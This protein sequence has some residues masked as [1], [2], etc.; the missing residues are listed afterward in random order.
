M[1]LSDE[2]LEK[3]G[4][5]VENAVDRRFQEFRAEMVVWRQETNASLIGIVQEMMAMEKRLMARM[6][7]LE[8]RAEGLENRTEALEREMLALKTL[9]LEVQQTVKK[10]YHEQGAT[11]AQVQDGITMLYKRQNI[12]EQRADHLDFIFKQRFSTPPTP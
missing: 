5:L 3:I 1:A 4:K 8:A 12:L 11:L 9:I 6:D 7:T 2:D 10:I